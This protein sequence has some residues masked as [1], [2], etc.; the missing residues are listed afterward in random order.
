MKKILT[1]I[2]L[3]ILIFLQLGCS[4]SIVENVSFA[5]DLELI[6]PANTQGLDLLTTIRISDP[7]S[8]TDLEF[9]PS[10]NFIAESWEGAG[11]LV[12]RSLFPSVDVVFD[13]PL[14]GGRF[15]RMQ[16]LPDNEDLILQINDGANSRLLSVETT[17]F[18]LQQ[19]TQDPLAISMAV[20]IDGAILASAHFDPSSSLQWIQIRDTARW[21]LLSTNYLSA[22][23]SIGRLEHLAFDHDSEHLISG[24]SLGQIEY[25]DIASLDI[26]ERIF[27][28]V[29]QSPIEA[30]DYNESN[31]ILAFGVTDNVY[32]WHQGEVKVLGRHPERVRQ[33]AFNPNGTLLA[34][35]SSR[36]LLLWNIDT[37]QLVANIP[38]QNIF[39]LFDVDFSPDGKLLAIS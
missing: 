17:N 18:T 15:Q 21:H 6:T 37:E 16:F 10:G 34:S 3:Q 2:L 12:I 1:A 39:G 38:F 31:M 9:S 23:S 22:I 35:I 28:S 33:L 30:M 5:N 20:S 14:Y 4:N 24:N 8:L 27:E 19:I 36:N 26:A 13:E 25:W 11:R 32:I 7:G 29:D